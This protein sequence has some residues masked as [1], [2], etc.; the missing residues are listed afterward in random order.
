MP[1]ENEL[2][3]CKIG[4][5]ALAGIVGVGASFPLDLIKTKFQ[6]NKVEYQGKFSNAYKAVVAERGFRGL[7]G[8]IGINMLLITPE[9]AIKLVVNDRMRARLTDKM[10]ISAYRIR[11]SPEP[12]PEPVN[13][14]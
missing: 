12:L 5:G 3:L 6:L 8:G 1:T 13:A 10:G 2:L 4:N 9:K 14:S 7:Y 11:S